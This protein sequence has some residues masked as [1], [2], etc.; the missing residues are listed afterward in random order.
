MDFVRCDNPRNLFALE[1]IAVT[2]TREEA[3]RTLENTGADFRRAYR[4]LR[5]LGRT[6]LT[7]KARPK[8]QK[9][10]IAEQ[11]RETNACAVENFQ[12]VQLTSISWNRLDLYNEVWSQPLVKLSQ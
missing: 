6:F 2:S 1:G 10:V 12:D 8:L 9:G 11:A 5:K 4:Q 7:Q 3:A